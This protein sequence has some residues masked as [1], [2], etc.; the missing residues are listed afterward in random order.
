MRRISDARGAAGGAWLTE[1]PGLVQ[2]ASRRWDLSIDGPVIG[3]YNI[4][5][6]VRRA[7][8]AAC[9]LKLSPAN[10]DFRS[11]R[12]AL[13]AFTPTGA[14]ARLFESDDSGALLIERIEPGTMLDDRDP[15]ESARIAAGLAVR[16]HAAA[17]PPGMPTYAELFDGARDRASAYRERTDFPWA[18]WDARVPAGDSLDPDGRPHV[19]LHEDLHHGNILCSGGSA[20]VAIDP[21]GRAGHPVHEV[22]QYLFNP[23]ASMVL[24]RRQAIL[25]RPDAVAVTR[26]RIRTWAGVLGLDV[27]ATLR[28]AAARIALNAFWSLEDGDS[29]A[30]SMRLAEIIEAAG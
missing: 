24:D 13:A 20:W 16:L 12:F 4:V 17:I 6:P 30:T 21:H 22:G 29:W 11:E 9:M 25:D 14:S 28:A 19:L 7:G 8:G 27:E 1:L 15:E 23:H 2:R 26:L 5:V 18:W 3:N 10:E